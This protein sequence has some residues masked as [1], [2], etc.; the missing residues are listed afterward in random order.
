LLANAVDAGFAG[1]MFLDEALASYEKQRND[2]AL[3]GYEQNCAAASFMPPPPVV[4]ARRAAAH[5]AQRSV[6]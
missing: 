1:R 4:M 6:P 5:A 2:A 3:P